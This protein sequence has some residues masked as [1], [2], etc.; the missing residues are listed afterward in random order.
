[1]ITI[2]NVYILEDDEYLNKRVEIVSS[3]RKQKYHK[4]LHMVGTVTRTS[5]GEVGVT[6]D[7]IENEASQYGVFWFKR[8]EL[9]IMEDKN[10]TGF[11]R[12]AIVNLLDDYNKKDY[13]FAL[14]EEDLKLLKGDGHLVVVNARG[15]NNRILGTVKNIMSVEEYGKNV[16][17]QVVG[18]VNMDR[19]DA[20][21]AEENRLAE[22]AKKKAEIEKALDVEIKKRKD[23][24]YYE[25][26]AK[27]YSDNPLIVQLVEELKGLGA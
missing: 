4:L 11:E 6:V 7:G 14:Y 25:K 20:E 21:I 1:M 13:G 17:A 8:H 18:V 9:R 10:M 16:T 26:M 22:I 24:E 5:S 3:N 2:S 12:V 23:A 27:E 19:Y 15:K